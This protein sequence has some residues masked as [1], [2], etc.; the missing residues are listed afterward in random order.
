MGLSSGEVVE[1]EVEPGIE[2]H[3]TDN[4]GPT[5]SSS[6]KNAVPKAFTDRQNCNPGLLHPRVL[7][8]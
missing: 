6:K 7:G 1:V 5:P 3:G 4:L 8:G 2:P